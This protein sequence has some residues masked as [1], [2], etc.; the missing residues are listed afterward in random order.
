ML[1]AFNEVKP[2]TFEEIER[3]WRT[4][5][6]PERVSK[7]EPVSWISPGG[8]IDMDLKIGAPT[9][10]GVY[11]GQGQE[12]IGVVSGHSTGG[13]HYRSRGLWVSET[14]RGQGMA[15]ALI[16]K[17]AEVAKEE[18]HHTLWT[19]PRLSSWPFYQKVRFFETGRSEKYEFGPHVLAARNL[20]EPQ[21]V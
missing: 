20:S 17:L 8:E 15:R 19:M 13:G 18:G 12:I 16:E 1:P 9:F 7:I 21:G 2:I 6:W 4:R 5:L 11:S 3:I 14:F 10:L